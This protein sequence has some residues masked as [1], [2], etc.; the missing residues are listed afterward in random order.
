M[1]KLSI[2]LAGLVLFSSCKKDPDCEKNTAS[3][4]GTYKVASYGYKAT[5]SSP[6][7]DYYHTLFPDAC[8]RDNRLKFETNGTYQLVD[9]D[10]VCSPPGDDNGTWSLS[11]N[12]MVI[13]GDDTAIESFDCKV[14]VLSNTDINQ[15]GDQLKI[16]LIRQ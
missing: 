8:D 10:L 16:T 2:F 15:P 12:S 14:L 7:I 3:I 6:E 1:K 4:S 11:G 9:A 13:D 5:P